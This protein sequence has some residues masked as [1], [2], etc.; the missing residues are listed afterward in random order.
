M[1]LVVRKPGSFVIPTD[2]KKL[3]I[4][5]PFE[6]RK[7][8]REKSFWN[9]LMFNN[10]YRAALAELKKVSAEALDIAPCIIEA[11]QAANRAER[12]KVERAQRA[13]AKA[14]AKFTDQFKR[15]QAQYKSDALENLKEAVKEARPLWEDYQ[16]KSA[17][18]EDDKPRR[19]G[20]RKH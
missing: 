6:A 5:V 20:K 12:E 10:S 17:G 11:E 8:P 14:F 19:K 15:F 18:E 16:C 2:D 3:I 1:P 4:D 13:M 7:D 9:L